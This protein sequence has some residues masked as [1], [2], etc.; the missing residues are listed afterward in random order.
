MWPLRRS[1]GRAVGPQLGLEVGS[2]HEVTGV[3]EAGRRHPGRFGEHGEVRRDDDEAILAPALRRAAHVLRRRGT[4][5]DGH[6]REDDSA[7]LERLFVEQPDP[8][9]ARLLAELLPEADVVVPAHGRQRCDVGRR[10]PAEHVSEIARVLELHRVAQQQDQIDLRLGEPRE[11]RVG[12][13]VELLGLEDVDPARACRLE[14][15]VQVAE[16]ADQHVRY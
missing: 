5:C 15:A 14:L 11:R 8:V 3:R 16:D 4:P 10:E 7:E 6:A 2:V 1:V 13:P 9:L 12:A